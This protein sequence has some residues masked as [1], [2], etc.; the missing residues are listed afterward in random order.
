MGLVIAAALIL[1]PACAAQDRSEAGAFSPEPLR[2][3]GPVHEAEDLSA[4]ESLGE[5]LIIGSDEG[6]RI[7]VLE[8]PE[9]DGAYRAR[10]EG[11]PLTGSGEEVDVEGMARD[12]DVLYVLGSHALKRRL[13]KPDLSQAENRRRLA[14]VPPEQNRHFVF[15]LAMNP[16]TGEPAGPVDAV[17]LRPILERDPVLGPFTR[18]PG[19]ENGVNLE[20]I[21]VR[22]SKLYVGFRSP[23]LREGLVPVMVFPFDDPANY[24]L[25]YVQL[26]GRG[27][28]SMARVDAGFLL[29]ARSDRGGGKRYGVYLWDGADQVPG[30]DAL[31]SS[32]RL[33]ADW[34]ITH[35]A[36]EGLALLDEDEKRYLVIVVHDGAEGGE[37]VRAHIFKVRR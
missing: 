16:E 24:T 13:I 5:F 11:I 15:R 25:R 20:G 36:P 23:V 22:D 14:D 29:L 8:P 2:F 4:V 7:Q 31:I 1:L 27:I 35:G 37:P 26:G 3:T 10:T 19:K 32:V 28:R 21:A 34:P 6:D 12:G 18:I 33:L 30:S 9:D 17:S